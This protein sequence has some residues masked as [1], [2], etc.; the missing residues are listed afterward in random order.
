MASVVGMQG[1]AQTILESFEGIPSDGIPP[2]PPLLSRPCPHRDA[3][4]GGWHPG[5]TCSAVVS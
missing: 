2:P 5:C 4:K 3:A 1:K